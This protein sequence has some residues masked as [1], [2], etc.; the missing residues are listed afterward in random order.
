M[1]NRL[2]LIAALAA[3]GLLLRMPHPARDIAKLE[4]VRAVHLFVEGEAL[5]IRTDTGDTGR[6]KDLPQAY[7]DL[8]SKAD[9]EIFLDTAAFLILDP[10]VPITGVLWEIFRP[11]CRVRLRDEWPELE[12]AAEYL[13]QHP[14]DL[15]LARLRASHAKP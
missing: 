13:S 11:D 7:A 3:A 6:G 2:Y 14:P 10:D 15:T 8:R 1:K 4:P 12:R 5:S 9:G